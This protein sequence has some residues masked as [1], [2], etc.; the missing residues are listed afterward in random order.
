MIKKENNDQGRQRGRF[1]RQVY[2]KIIIWIGQQEVWPRI[3]GTAKEKLVK[4]KSKGK[5]EKDQQRK[6]RNRKMEQRKQTR[7]PTGFLWQVVEK[8][9]GTR[10]RLL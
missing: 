6:R 4:I 10:M 8:I 3:L 7:K 2:S 1:A 9:L 5:N